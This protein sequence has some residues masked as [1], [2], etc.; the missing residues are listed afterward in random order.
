M[1]LPLLS[2]WPSLRQKLA[3]V[4]LGLFPTPVERLESLERA[5]SC[6]VPLYTKR[7]DLSSP[8]YGGNKI[9]TLEVLF[10]RARAQGARQIVAMGAFGSNHAVATVLHAPAAELEAGAIVFA[11]PVSWAALENLRVTAARARFFRAVSHWSLLPFAIRG[12]RSA[13]RAL[14]APGG[15]TP[16]GALGYVSAGLELAEQVRRGELEAPR[17]IFVGVGSTCTS[18]GLLVGLTL[19]ARFGIGFTAPPALV[20]VRVT[21]WPVTSRFRILGLAERTARHLAALASEPSLALRRA[22]LAPMLTVDGGELGAGYGLA[23]ESGLRAL[24]TF[25]ELGLFALDTTYSSKAAAGFLRAACANARGPLLFWST[26]STA[27]LPAIQSDELAGVPR[28]VR[29]WLARAERE[30]APSQRA[31]R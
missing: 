9:R 15:A 25:R 14:M 16:D 8:I 26:K 12:A 11:Q 10:G 6:A 22:E 21:P 7:D 23:S 19:A 1:A 20:A 27:A 28:P 5:L 2:I 4:P 17:A 18:A 3:P 29:R 30:L 13:E 24:E 31:G